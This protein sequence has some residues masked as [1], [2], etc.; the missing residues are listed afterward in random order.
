[1]C[2]SLSAPSSN[3]S[4]RRDAA[5]PVE[6]RIG[7]TDLPQYNSIRRTEFRVLDRSSSLPGAVHPYLYHYQYHRRHRHHHHHHYLRRRRPI[8]APRRPSVKTCERPKAAAHTN[9]RHYTSSCPS[10]NS[11]ACDG[12]TTKGR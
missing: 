3:F 1:M 11:F 10:A 8:P 4:T 9:C 7:R 5:D 12:T 6:R 2:T